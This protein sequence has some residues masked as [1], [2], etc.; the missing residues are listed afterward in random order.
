MSRLV[1]GVAPPV[2]CPY[3]RYSLS[4]SISDGDFMVMNLDR[5]IGRDR[6][7]VVSVLLTPYVRVSDRDHTASVTVQFYGR[8]SSDVVGTWS[9]TRTFGQNENPLSIPE[10]WVDSFQRY[11]SD[12]YNVWLLLRAYH[13]QSQDPRE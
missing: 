6:R 9:R 5:F 12:A 1:N 4:S 3:V 11:C 10:E 13:N 7:S 8:D 2:P